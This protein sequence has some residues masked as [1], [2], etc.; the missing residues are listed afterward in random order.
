M[1]E[2]PLPAP[3]RLL[4]WD[5]AFFG[6][7]VAQVTGDTLDP[8]RAA[9][10]DRWCA[11]NDVAC[12]YFL[13]RADDPRTCRLAEEG[14]YRFVDIRVT[15]TRTAAALADERLEVSAS[16]GAA[17]RHHA[18]GDVE[19]LAAL[20]RESHRDSRF[21]ADATF[22]RRLCDALYETWIR[23]SCDGYADAVLVAELD[24][25]VAGYITCH[26]AAN[27]RHGKIGLVGVARAARG[28]GIGRSLVGHALAWH[29]AHGAAEVSVVTQGRNCAAQ[30]LYQRC[31]FTTQQTELWYHKWYR[32]GPGE[33]TDG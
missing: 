24:G 31:G 6:V 10:I 12:L 18:P 9:R 32:P 26:R 28:R 17:V 2:P 20:A 1:P 7:R 14:G 19:A 21:Y 15:L 11:E 23:R 30:R 25:A 27:S 16:G 4:D 5:S 13:A 29:A 22:P 8:E 3:C 33:E